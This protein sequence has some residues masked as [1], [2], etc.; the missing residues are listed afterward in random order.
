MNGRPRPNGFA[1]RA[2]F[3]PASSESRFGQEGRR[4][5]HPPD[6]SRFKPRANAAAQGA[7]RPGAGQ[8]NGRGMAG[9]PPK[10]VE[11][12]RNMSPEEQ[13]R[14][15]RNNQRFQSLP[16]ERQAQVRR[17]LQ[18]WNRLSPT[19]RDAIRDRERVWEQ[20][21]PQQRE[22][23]KDDLLPKWQQMPPDRKQLLMGR[24][25]TL[26]GMNPADRQAALNDPKFMEGL[27]P[28]EQ[29]VLRDLNSLRNP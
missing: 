27:N 8:G 14:F 23:V 2:N 29:G 28:D 6:E 20:M 1:G 15:M 16:P 24:L 4:A 19:E 10:W 21:S 17:N 11:N 9:L 12:L 22:H 26:Q 18:K 3:V 13:D 5:A 25:H 7:N